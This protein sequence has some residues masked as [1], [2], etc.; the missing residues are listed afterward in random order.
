LGVHHYIEEKNPLKLASFI[1]KQNGV[2]IVAHPVKYHYQIP[3]DLLSMVDGIEIWNTSYDGRFVPNVHSLNLVRKF[4]KD[5]RPIL[6]FGGQ[7]LHEIRNHCCVEIRMPIEKLTQE[8]VL[9][10]LKKGDF[11][12]TNSYLT[13][14][15]G[16]EEKPV[17]LL[18]IY[19]LRRLYEM[20]TKVRRKV[21]KK[22][23][24]R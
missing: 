21:T 7:D 22:G 23:G 8:A 15:P 3:S 14:S 13:L 11:K 16:W 4:K 18:Q 1:R 6:G 24:I 20:A 5:G 12:I 10:S 19:I 2:A 9:H 17:K